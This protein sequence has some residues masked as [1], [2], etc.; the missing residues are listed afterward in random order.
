[1]LYLTILTRYG[2]KFFIRTAGLRDVTFPFVCLKLRSCLQIFP[3]C[4]VWILP[5]SKVCR[6]GVLVVNTSRY[7]SLRCMSSIQAEQRKLCESEESSWWAGFTLAS[8]IFLSLAVSIG[9]NIYF[10]IANWDREF[11]GSRTLTFD[12]SCSLHTLTVVSYNRSKLDSATY[13]VCHETSQAVGSLCNV[14]FVIFSNSLLAK[15]PA[16]SGS[17]LLRRLVT[18]THQSTSALRLS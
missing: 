15:K 12:C 7:P 17:A 2:N 4:L 3:L 16:A 5:D 8:V 6:Y 18:P 13:L 14:R 1:M 9:V 11:A 10:I